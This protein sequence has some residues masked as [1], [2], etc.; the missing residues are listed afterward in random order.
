MPTCES[1]F[2]SRYPIVV[3]IPLQ[4]GDQD[5]FGH[6]NNI[7]FLRWFESSRIEYLHQ[8]GIEISAEKIGPILA[9][10]HCNFKLQLR[11]PDTVLIGSRLEKL[12]NSSLTI[13]HEVYSLDQ[14]QIVADGESVIVNFDYQQQ[15]SARIDDNVRERMLR[16][17]TQK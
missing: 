3:E 11:F 7:V 10:V 4:W 2:R 16:S 6:V 9:A 14:Q 17:S 15:K 5:S 1:E 8:H 12:G 13:A